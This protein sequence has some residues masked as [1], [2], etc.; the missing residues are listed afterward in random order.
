VGGT[1]AQVHTQHGL[2]DASSVEPR[3]LNR[4]LSMLDYN[5][6]V[7]ARAEDPSLPLLERVLSLHYFGQNL[8]DFF[9]I[10]VAGLKELLEAAPDLASPD[11]MSP[12]A[13][14]QEIRRRVEELSRRQQDLFQDDLRPLLA[15]AGIC[16]VE[17]GDLSRKDVE[18]LARYFR[19]SIFPVLTPL[20][21]DPGHPFPYISHFSLNLAVVV[22]HPLRR[23]ERFA[24][25]KVPPLLPRFI[26]LPDG[27]RFVP[28]EQ[29][30]AS[31]LQALF[32]G[33]EIVSHSA[34]RVTRDNDL[35]VR[36]DE[37][38]DLLVTIQAELLRH[39]RRARAVRLEIEPDMPAEVRELLVRELELT[40]DDVYAV[41]GLLDLSAVAYFS[42]LDRPDLKTERYAPVGPPRLTRRDGEAAD[43][44]KALQTGDVLVH[45]PY[46][47]F[48]KSVVAFTEQAAADPQVLAIKQT[49]Y[50]TSG[51]ASP[52]A[53]ALAGAA[54]AGKQVV[55][56]VELKARGDE[57]ANIAWA[58]ALEEAGV[59]VVYGLV[60]L[61]THAKLTLV[62]RQE[63]SGIRRYVHVATGNYNPQTALGYEDVG[64]F[65]A[66]PD[67][68]ADVSELFNFLTGYS[69]Q[70]RFRRLLVAPASL[71]D[72]VLEL[73]RE[74]AA[75]EDGRIV[76][77]ANNLVDVQVVDSLYE[78]SRAGVQVDLIIRSMC[79]L[80]PEVPGLSEHIRVRSLVGRF[81]EHSRILRFGSE[82][83]GYRYYIGSADMMDRNLDRRVEAVVPVLD[84][85]LGARLG[86]ILEVELADDRLSW[87]LDGDGRW[88][89]VPEE[90]GLDAQQRFEELAHERA[91]TH[92]LNGLDQTGAA[93]GTAY[94]VDPRAAG[95]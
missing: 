58:H 21:V 77:K 19:K 50:R 46:E 61:K 81:L 37:A 83:R 66:D 70:R 69:R 62:V 26:A 38:D 48:A 59:H 16:L 24:R 51:P 54:E 22:R 31:N 72:G 91:R 47:S 45:H 87:R 29:V 67:L 56:L 4:E 42:E 89:R 20:A 9:Q 64:L 3:Y 2:A 14:L 92:D 17:A 13:Q 44:F 39:R 93:L 49:L 5:V 15:E 40:G 68:G 78:A 63:A 25:L 41:E 65:S 28:L 23:Q 71:R 57:Q 88:S 79:V 27:E 86:E 12:G 35:E 52:I 55:A 8:D 82:E 53:L 10:R 84:P 32:P 30:I 18:H 43:F 1:Q 74:E 85:A 7:L 80:R 36:E 73:I 6:R 34:F 94:A 76:I 95:A 75:H 33:M 90:A 11:G 60:G